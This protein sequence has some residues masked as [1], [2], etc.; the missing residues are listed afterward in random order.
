MRTTVQNTDQTASQNTDQAASS[1]HA[2][3]TDQTVLSGDQ[4]ALP[5][6]AVLSDDHT[7]SDALALV[8]QVLSE[9]AGCESA[10]RT[11]AFDQM[12]VCPPKG[13]ERSGEISADCKSL[14]FQKKHD[15][16]FIRAVLTLHERRDA[17]SD[18]N[19]AMADRLY[20]EHLHTRNLSPAEEAWNGKAKNRAWVAWTNALE[21]N[22]F[23]GFEPALRDV[24][25][26]EKKR[27]LLADYPETEKDMQE[28]SAY[29]R[30][31]DEFETGIRMPQLDALFQQCSGRILALLEQIRA[32]QKQIRTDFMSR[33][34]TDEQQDDLTHYLLKLLCFD[35]TSGTCAFSE[36]PFTERL[37]PR[38]TRITTHY[39]PDNF[40]SSM[41][42]VLH[43]CGHALFEQMQPDENHTYFLADAKT[44]GMHESVSRFYENIIGRSRSFIQLIYPKL[45]EL[46]P[47]VFYDVSMDELY[48]AVNCV[49]PSLIRMDAD[50]LTYTLHIII[51]YEIEKEL[52]DGSLDV[53]D[54]PVVWKEKY[55]KYLGI[56]PENDREGALQDSHWTSDFGYFPTYALGNLYGAMFATSIREQFDLDE[57]IL[58]GD[59]ATINAWMAEHVFRRADRLTADQWILEITGRPLSVED[60]LAYLEEK[61]SVLYGLRAEEGNNKALHDYAQRLIRIRRLSSLQ[62]NS[63][64]NADEYRRA[65]AENFRK[66]GELARENRG[67]IDN[68]ID[69][70]LAPGHQLPDRLVREIHVFNEK[71]MDAWTHEN[72]D[73][74]IMSLLSERLMVDASG[75]EDTAYLVRQLDEEV[76]ACIAMVVQSRRIIS[77]P[78]I[79]RIFRRRGIAALE[80]LLTWLDHDR[81]LQLDE[82]CRTLVMI[83]SRYADGLFVTMTPLTQEERRYR[84]RLT[85]RALELA[86]DPFYREAL[87]NYDWQYHIYRTYQYISSYD[88]FNN[89]AGNTPDELQRIADCGEA[90]EEMI[91]SDPVSLGSIDGF[92][93]THTHTCRNRM[94]AGRITREEF[95]RELYSLYEKRQP[96]LYDVNSISDNI[97]LPREY[98]N[99]LDMDTLSEEEGDRIGLMYQNALSY[100]FLM[101]KL[102]VFY[103]LMDHYAPLLFDFREIPGRLSFEEMA[104]RSF[105]AV[106]PP[107]YVHSLMVARISLCLCTHII[108]TSPEILV[109]I[110]DTKTPGEVQQRA[111][112]IKDFLYH[113]ALCHDFG[114]LIIIDTIFMYGRKI[115]DSEFFIIKQ[116]PDLG[117]I[118]LSRHDS[119][120]AYADIARGHHVWY[121]GSKGYPETFPISESPLKAAIDIVECADCMDAA[122]DRVGRI[123]NTGISL[124]DYMDEV[125]K[126]AG[127]R[128][129]PY[130]PAL[131]KRKE[132]YD[133]LNYLLTEGRQQAYR[134]TWELLKTVQKQE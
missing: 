68:V 131:F 87:P 24:I 84:F 55:L 130:F 37:T 122:T 64:N 36:H 11:I 9:A 15:P 80:Q 108:R 129:A 23:S 78:D 107:T 59:F 66:I 17:L 116:H 103:E 39:Y 50:E 119:T 62:V 48:E 94:H 132:V 32:Q 123:Y 45:T 18:W 98:I 95:S 43:E 6:Q 90:L 104:L 77:S 34:V 31:L 61:Y 49:T 114:K 82:E 52:I 67:V 118:L 47:Q 65:L 72:I 25:E 14:A 2:A 26:S 99:S 96:E 133:D 117:A 89:A 19:R 42:S 73:L 75:K 86:E 4:S 30:M 53:H 124:D 3:F 128:Y 120:R 97:A 38:D 102:G 110:L 70:I 93:Y 57:A 69:P 28:A 106:H 51:R 76:V 101:P 85:Q 112:A 58:D 105:A 46:L 56:A 109:G 71:L 74:N 54:V 40:A 10:A 134:D 5:G 91:L 8:R 63:V 115:L 1:D 60:F 33:L 79:A 100:V 113:A 88:E 44:M 27:V 22:D 125:E 127:T 20:R 126:S 29:Q 12:T 13:R 21:A 16:A 111:S 81:F 92:I 41:Y 83:N 7:L 35:E 121:D